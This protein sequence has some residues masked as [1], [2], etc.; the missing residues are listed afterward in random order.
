ME[1]LETFLAI[2]LPRM[3]P[4][5]ERERAEVLLRRWGTAWQGPDRR[6]EATHSI[7][8][9]FLHFNQRL[10]TVWS[11]AFGFRWTGRHGLSLRGPDPDRARK[12]HK[13][14]AHKLDRAP[15]DALFEAWG[16]HPEA[17]PAGQAV[18]FFFTETPEDTWEA[19]LQEALACL[20]G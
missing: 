18:E 4:V 11:Q 5:S 17:H 8:G 1:P 6:L 9:A 13:L 14:R 19:C 16:A 12:S 7:H 2:V 20:R 3:H 10:G 15:L